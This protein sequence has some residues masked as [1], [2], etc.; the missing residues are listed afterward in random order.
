MLAYLLR[1]AS[2]ALLTV[3]LALTF[4]FLLLRVLPEDAISIQLT[5]SGATE[6][7]I[8]ER[9]A[10]LGL[11][12]PFLI[13][14]LNVFA[15]LIRGDLGISLSSGRA[16]ATIISEQ[17]PSTLVLSFGSLGIGI[18]AGI[19]LGS[20]AS[21]SKV[22]LKSIARVSL[23]F[24]LAAPVYWTGTLAIYIFA[25]WLGWLPSTGSGRDI[26]SLILPWLVL[27]LSIAGSIGQ[28]TANL[29]Q[30]SEAAAY[31]RTG[32]AKGLRR[33]T[34]FWR[35][36]LKAGASGLISLIG[37]QAG[38]V[39]GGAALTEMLFVRRGI[40]QV[41]FQA[42][43]ERDYPV[44]QG[45]VMLSALIY[46]LTGILT[47]FLSAWVDPRLRQSESEAR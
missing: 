6:T 34:L 38:F 1:R 43:N 25:V 22:P 3:W 28:F 13:Q 45:I 5:I 27:G 17:F 14:Y 11:D 12:Q 23:T 10:S 36:R 9:R 15:G 19:G 46:A 8:S 16:V 37:L 39:L 2:H 26:R 42:V 4:A 18:F 29:L 24:L 7:Q 31:L 44:V 35:Y 41:L 40:G 30:E 21:L 33:R 32:R 20:A 47:D